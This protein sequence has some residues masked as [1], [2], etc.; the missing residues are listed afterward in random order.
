MHWSAFTGVNFVVDIIS[1]EEHGRT[2]GVG[3]LRSLNQE[4]CNVAYTEKVFIVYNVIAYRSIVSY[5]KLYF[6]GDSVVLRRESRTP[7]CKILCHLFVPE[8]ILFIY[9]QSLL[10]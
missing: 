1:I 2:L 4:I 6:N 9:K 8:S 3:H 7:N 10:A 5:S